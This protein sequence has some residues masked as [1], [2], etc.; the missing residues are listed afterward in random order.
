MYHFPVER[1][2]WFSVV[3]RSVSR[4]YADV[5]ARHAEHQRP[6]TYFNLNP[7]LRLRQGAGLSTTKADLSLHYDATY[8]SPAA[9]WSESVEHLKE[10][11]TNDYPK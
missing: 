7:V 8:E 2:I 4:R 1:T 10:Q 3:Q 6:G 9:S 11:L 5:R